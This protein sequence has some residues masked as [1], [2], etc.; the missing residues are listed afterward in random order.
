M[1]HFKVVHRQPLFKVIKYYH[2]SHQPSPYHG[3]WTLLL[4]QPKLKNEEQHLKIPINVPTTD[5]ATTAIITSDNKP[6]PETTKVVWLNN[7]KIVLPDKPPP[8]ENCCMS[9][10]V[11]CVYDIYQEDMELYKEQLDNIRNRFKAAGKELPDILKRKKDK[12][13]DDEMDPTMRAFLEMEKK[14]NSS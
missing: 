6:P 7:E 11:H 14:L 2:T 13:I 8:P 3:Y 1:I 4:Q 12:K 9:G 10:C 5:I